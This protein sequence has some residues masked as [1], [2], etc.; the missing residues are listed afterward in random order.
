MATLRLRGNFWVIDYRLDGKRKV[1]STKIPKGQ[2]KLAEQYFAE[3]QGKMARRQIGWESP[4]LS[5]EAAAGK[6]LDT[7]KATK[8]PKT[9]IQYK[10]RIGQ[11]IDWLKSAH[12]NISL[13]SEITPE[14]LQ[15]FVNHRATIRHPNTVKNSFI[16]VRGFFN[17]CR[18][19]GYLPANP[20]D[21]VD[22]P[23]EKKKPI[24]FFSVEDVQLIFENAGARLPFYQFLY[25]SLAR[26]NE[27]ATFRVNQV[28]FS[29]NVLIFHNTKSNR[30]DEV[31]I[32]GKLRPILEN[33]CAGKKTDDL[34]FPNAFAKRH[35]SLRLEFQDLLQSIELPHATIHTWRHTGISHLVMA[36]VTLRAVKEIARHQDIKT[37]MRYSH[38]APGYLKGLINHLPV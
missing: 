19:M 30:Y 4:T 11:V 21:G 10:E 7:I 6:W 18:K 8:A 15:E 2:K 27:A 23:R 9:Y 14:V 34:L 29:R 3:F 28:N 25:Y 33:L 38:L 32:A 26:L 1:K 20:G 12:P 22:L 35:N 36:G 16:H 13:L 31:E 37:T 17:W 5:L 24:R